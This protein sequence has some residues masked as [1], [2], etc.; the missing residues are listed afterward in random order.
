MS[1]LRT[2]ERKLIKA[3]SLYDTAI[4]NI[5]IEISKI[6]GIDDLHGDM[7]SGDGLGIAMGDSDAHVGIGDLINV[8]ESTGKITIDD[9]EKTSF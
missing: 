9:L 1:K 8:F 2:L 3:E 6:S 4:N 7:L 5:V